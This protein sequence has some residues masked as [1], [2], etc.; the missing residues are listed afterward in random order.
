MF[1]IRRKLEIIRP[2]LYLLNQ[3]EKRILS[4]Y[5]F[6]CFASFSLDILSVFSIFPFVNVIL[7]PNMVYENNN[8]EYLWKLLGS[9]IKDLFI[10]YLAISIVVIII[11]SSSLSLFTQYKLTNFVSKCQR[12]LGNDLLQKFSYVNYEWHIQQ[13]SIK[14][15]NLFGTHIVYWG[16]G[17]IKQIPLLVG[18]ISSLM[19]PIISVMILSPKFGLLLIVA[20]STLI[21]KFLQA[22]RIQTNRLSNVQRIK[23][24]EITICL[25]E[26]LQGIKDVKL[27]NNENNFFL[28]FDNLWNSFIQSQGIVQNFN[29]LPVN[30]ILM[31]SQLS[32]VI[33]GTILYR[34]GINEK[35]LVGTMAIITL[36]AF[37][38]VPILSRLGNSLN[39]LSNCQIFAKHLKQ[40]Y[41]EVELI[42]NQNE[43]FKKVYKDFSWNKLSLIDVSYSY[44]NSN[45]ISLKNINLEIKRGLHY[46]FVGFSGAGKTTVVDICNGLLQPHEGKVLIDGY[47]LKKFGIKRWQTKIG[48]VPQ[49]PKIND[50]TIKENIAFG[51][52]LKEIDEEKVLQCLEIVGLKNFVQRLPLKLSTELKEGGKLFSG[53]QQQLIA[54]ARA[55]YQNPDILIL[56]EATNSLD[57]ITQDSIR[58]A[59]KNLHGKVTLLS[60]SHQFTNLKFADHIFLFENG[61]IV[62]EGN[63]QDLYKS[64]AL[65][66]ELSDYQKGS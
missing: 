58:L 20:L 39:N 37:K 48:Y 5:C 35:E 33:I 25:N 24:D 11:I 12:R 29:L 4:L 23:N 52:E 15:M 43:D 64:S 40:I 49:K 2:S 56:D 17:V 36:L 21:F 8:L 3:K 19:I 14:L 60:I 46:G 16:K 1:A 59:F 41:S 57:S 54:I 31:F 32:V 34:S 7:E 13:N 62:D 53:G 6:L 44:P 50:A 27:T 65:F 30:L 61:E 9:P 66:K 47:D 45:K 63:S 22:I 26:I 18:F 38:V 42:N 55:L 51:Y 10:V 28:K